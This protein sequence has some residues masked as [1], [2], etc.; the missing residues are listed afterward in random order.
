LIVVDVNVL[1]DRIVGAPALRETAISVRE[2]DPV[3]IAPALWRY[4][5]GNILWMMVRLDK[6]DAEFAAECFDAAD[7]LREE[8][9][10]NQDWHQT[11]VLSIQHEVSYYDA[12]Y[13]Y[14][15]QS[16]GL[17]LFTRDRKLARKFPHC[18]NLIPSP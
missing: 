9:V 15:T 2:R 16:W 10:S 5:F 17:T 12:S 8:S 13:I 11:L 18:T 3:W 14:L 7:S 4:E 6:L 1:A